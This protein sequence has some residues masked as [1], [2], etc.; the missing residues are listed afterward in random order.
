MTRK[1]ADGI[2]YKTGLY[3]ELGTYGGP[4][5]I[6]SYRMDMMV[7]NNLDIL[8]DELWNFD[9]W[10]FDREIITKAQAYCDSITTRCHQN[11]S[12]KTAITTIKKDLLTKGL[13]HYDKYTSMDVYHAVL[14]ENITTTQAFLETHPLT[15]H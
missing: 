7:C 6:G 11:P 12:L 2:L 4:H 8:M 15:T 3:K 9:L 5:P 10:F 1:K 14:T 13:Y